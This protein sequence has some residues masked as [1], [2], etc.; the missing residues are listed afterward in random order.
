[1]ADKMASFGFAHTEMS[2]DLSLGIPYSQI[3]AL[4]AAAQGLL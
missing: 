4:R 1:M 3:P 2:L